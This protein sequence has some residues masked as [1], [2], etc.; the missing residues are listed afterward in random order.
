MSLVSSALLSL[1]LDSNRTQQESATHIGISVQ[2]LNDLL[3]ARRRLS[4]DVAVRLHRAYEVDGLDLYLTQAREDF[5]LAAER[6][7]LNEWDE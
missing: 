5:D 7:S 6:F 3:N 4:P 1:Q 2:Y